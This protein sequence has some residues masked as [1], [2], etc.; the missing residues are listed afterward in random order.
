[1]APAPNAKDN[2]LDATDEATVR[3]LGL[4]TSLLYGLAPP[5]P[6]RSSVPPS[7]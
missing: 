2:V 3:D 7:S 6:A 5:D 4:I 1:L